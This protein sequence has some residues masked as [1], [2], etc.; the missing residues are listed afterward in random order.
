MTLLKT[1]AVTAATLL[2]AA[3]LLLSA[4]QASAASCTSGSVDGPAPRTAMC[5]GTMFP[6]LPAFHYSDQA[7]ADLAATMANQTPDPPGTDRGTGDDSPTLPAEYTYLG[8]FIDHNL[9]LDGTTQPTA[10]VNPSSLTN[11]ESF[12]FD[13]NNVFGGGPSVDPQLY[14]SDHRHLLVSG[15]LGTPQPD[16]FPTV[17]GNGGVFDLARNSTAR[18]SWSSHAMTRPRSCL[19]SRLRSLPSTTTS[20]TRAGATPRL[21]S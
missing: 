17:T 14:A 6:T 8:Q 13:L 9:D 18:R 4:R 21:A 12:R 20:S 11:L 15:T 3:L 19:R 16:G 2:V 1:K 10:N 5:F 7:A